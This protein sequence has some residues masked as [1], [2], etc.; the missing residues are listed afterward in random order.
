MTPAEYIDKQDPE[1]R[2]LLTSIHRLIL[3]TNKNVS[4]GVSKMMGADMIQYK[5]GNYFTYGLASVKNHISLHLLPMYMNKPIHEKYTG[6]LTKA[7]FQKGCI[8]FKNASEMPLDKVEQL[9]TDCSKIDVV[10]MLE[11]R[12][13]K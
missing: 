9:L 13:K 10:A 2:A 6:L 5:T 8:N 7:T 12:K 1:R 3:K 11:K 4:P